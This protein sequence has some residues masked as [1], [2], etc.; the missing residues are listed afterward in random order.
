[1]IKKAKEQGLV[2]AMVDGD[3]DILHYAWDHIL[4][5]GYNFW[6]MLETSSLFCVSMS[7][8]MGLISFHKSESYFIRETINR[9]HR[10]C[11]IFTCLLM[12]ED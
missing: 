5:L 10:Y 7:I 8:Y 11:K 4:F 6:L 1:M 9:E 3:L 2:I 12:K